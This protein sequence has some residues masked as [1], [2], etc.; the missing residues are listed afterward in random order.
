[1]DWHSI[2]QYKPTVLV[3][4]FRKF[5]QLVSVVSPDFSDRAQIEIL[6]FV[7][8][9]DVTINDI[10]QYQH[11]DVIVSAGANSTYLQQRIDLPVLSLEVSDR[12]VLG[13]VTTATGLNSRSMLISS[14][15]HSGILQ[16]LRPLLPATVEH[17]RY[18]TPDE[19][20]TLVY[21]AAKQGYQLIIGSSYVCS[22]AEQE[23]IR[24]LL[25]YSRD[26]CRKLLQDAISTGIR[27]RTRQLARRA[28]QA[29]LQFN[30]VAA[31]VTDAA[32]ALLACNPAAFSALGLT[33][34]DAVLQASRHLHENVGGSAT[35]QTTHPVTINGQRCSLRRL[36]LTAGQ[37]AHGYC[38]ALQIEAESAGAKPNAQTHT[39]M[40]SSDE[41]RLLYGSQS[42]SRLNKLTT[43]Y[44]QTGATVLITG[45]S[46]TG[47]ELIAREIHRRSPFREGEFVAINCGAIPDELF[48]SELFG[49]AEGAFTTSLKGGRTGLLAAAQGGVFFLD[50]ISELPLRQQAKILRVIQERKLR[51]LGSNREISL[52]VKFVC[53]S[54]QDLGKLVTAGQFRQDLFYRLNVLTLQVPPLHRRR[55][56]ILPI[57]HWMLTTQARHYGLDSNVDKLLAS[58]AEPLKRYRWPGNVRE[59]E[60][61]IERITAAMVSDGSGQLSERLRRL[62]PELY[63]DTEPNQGAS[64]RDRNTIPAP[65]R[66]AEMTMIRETLER[67]GGNRARTAEY[68][69]I[70]TT[71]LWRRLQRL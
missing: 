67:F 46:G 56:D 16:T 43:A 7:F 26:S 38:L 36:P 17:A 19:A 2:Q 18:E 30:S 54:N 65:L 55:A 53:A 59:L 15:D 68:L 51:P 50:E 47:K 4:G 40:G 62:A 42:M 35:A 25:L 48:E 21:L 11:A 64:T 8:E 23:N 70:S 69:G 3:V 49:Y 12:D 9:K 31:L 14:G 28:E 10:L 60:N 5:S 13:A 33:E 52:N 57:A 22:L 37:P 6:D 44:A 41:R 27:E 29:A 71:T 58:L 24:S 34:T 32:G 1:M 66:E 20:R 45:E 63:R 61:I 39:G